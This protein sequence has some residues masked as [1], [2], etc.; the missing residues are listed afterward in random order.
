[1]AASTRSTSTTM[2]DLRGHERGWTW[3]EI[4]AV[5]VRQA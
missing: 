1:M 5:R 3:M 4:C 2:N